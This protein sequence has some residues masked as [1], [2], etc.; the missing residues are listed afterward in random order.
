MR[1]LYRISASDLQRYLET[2]EE[3]LTESE[4]IQIAVASFIETPRSLLEVLVN[5]DYSSVVE[6]ARLHVNF[7]GTETIAEMLQNRNLG[8]NDRLAVEL[9]QFAPVAPCF[10]SE[11]VPESRLIQGLQNEYMPLRYRLQILE[12]LSQSDKLEPRLIVAESSETPVSLLELLAGDL[13]LAVRLTV[14]ANDNCPSEVVELVKSQH[15]LAN[16]WDGDVERL[17]ELGGSRWSWIRLTVAQNPFAP[18]DVLMN[19]ATDELFKVRLGVGKNPNSSARVLGVLAEESDKEI[20]VAVVEH[21]NTTEEM[22][23]QLFSSCKYEIQKRDNLPVSILERFYREAATDKPWEHQYLNLL[24][25]QVNTPTWILAELASNVDIEELTAKAIVRQDSSPV[26]KDLETFLGYETGFLTDIAKHPQVSVDIL[27]KLTQ[28]PSSQLKFTIVENP[29][30]PEELRVSL[31]QELSVNSKVNIKIKIA[32]NPQTPIIILEQLANKSYKLN[33]TEELLCELAPD[34]TPNLLKQIKTFI[35]KGQSPEMILWGLRQFT[36]DS[37]MEEWNDLENSLNESERETLKYLANQEPHGE[38]EGRNTSQTRS[39]LRRPSFDNPELAKNLNTLDGLMYLVNTQYNRDRTNQ[40]IV[41]ALLGNPSVPVNLRERLW[42]QHKITP[43]DESEYLEDWDM[44][45][46]VA[47][48]P[49]TSEEQ[50]VEYLQQ[51]L[52]NQ[53]SHIGWFAGEKIDR[54]IAKNPLTPKSILEFIIENIRRGIYDVLENPNAPI[55]ILRQAAQNDNST[56]QELIIKNPNTPKDLL[57][58]LTSGQILLQN[59][60]LTPLDIYKNYLEQQSEQQIEKAQR[61]MSKRNSNQRILRQSSSKQTPTLQSLPR[62]YNSNNDDLPTVLTEYI[63]SD[64]PFIRFVTLLHP[65]TPEEILTQAANSASWLERYA[66]AEN[67]STPS[68]IRLI[69]ARDANRIV[70]AA[71]NQNL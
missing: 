40:E 65:L 25:R 62:I 18:E 26:V 32:S 68:E 67:Q 42:E 57:E 48:N 10:L 14:E 5:S 16:D 17:R 50:R 29:K 45:M 13:E 24:L 36:A 61:L 44:R 63:D 22:L 21:L 3:L 56:I 60:N 4:E 41:A 35:Y 38:W 51:L 15:D 12:R 2:P 33:G 71:A 7:A 46:A 43:D 55:S 6:V 52:S 39:K 31:L 19:L 64:N 1:S 58:E 69:L 70:K 23:H 30:T 66:V 54:R 27:E 49:Q 8:Q 37:T 34:I 20:Q 28:Y 47:F 11:W 59:Q 9:M 53:V